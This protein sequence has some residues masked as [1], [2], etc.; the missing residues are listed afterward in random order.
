MKRIGFLVSLTVVL[1][2]T[3]ALSPVR[4]AE[5][6]VL[7]NKLVEKGVLSQPEATQ[8]LNEMQ[9]E[10]AR[11]KAE[12]EKTAAEA[13]KKETSGFKLPDLIKNTKIKGDVRLRYQGEDKY[14]DGDT[15]WRNR[16]RFR[17]RIYAETQVTE[18]WKAGFGLASGSADPRSTNQT[19]GDFFSS[20]GVNIDEAY[21]AYAPV[22]WLSL[23]G[24]K[25]ANPLWE[26]FDLLWDGDIR[27]EGIAANLGGKVLPNLEL[28]FNPALLVLQENS[29]ADDVYMLVFQP[30]L[31]WRL[32]KS[33]Y[34][35]LAGSYYDNNNLKGTEESEYGSGSNTLVDGKYIYDYDAF[36]AGAELGFGL[37]IPFMPFMSLFGQ[38]VNA[39]A[40]DQDTGYLAGVLVGDKKIKKFGDWQIVYNYRRLERNAWPDFLPDSDFF[41]GATNAKGS[42][43]VF[44]FGLTNN[45][46]FDVDWYHVQ[47]IENEADS[48]NEQDLVQVD[49]VVKF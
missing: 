23:V 32:G 5:V 28:F 19:L 48:L 1:I 15:V 45:V 3:F 35:T 31:T 9:R 34:L 11:Q 33:A 36:T 22:E 25:F 44:V 13:A 27:P 39:D 29:S 7:I 49:F 46:A 18:H 30:G 41:G 12:V 17:W 10:Q 6:D 42:E 16:G 4:A 40:D 24:G 47:T 37:P 8:L 26:P 21:A 20:K 2:M 14:S 38:Y 43:T